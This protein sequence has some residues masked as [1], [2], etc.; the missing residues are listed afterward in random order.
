[1]KTRCFTVCQDHAKDVT[2]VGS[3]NLPLGLS[4]SPQKGTMAHPKGLCG[5]RSGGCRELSKGLAQ[6]ASSTDDGSPSA[7]MGALRATGGTTHTGAPDSLA[8]Q[9]VP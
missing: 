1:M 8:G 9:V 7:V 3:L 2:A 4:V 6:S 5:D